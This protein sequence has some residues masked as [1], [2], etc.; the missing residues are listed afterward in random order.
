[1]DSELS[2]NMIDICPVGALTSKPF[3]YSAR[4][5]ELSRRKTVSPHDRT[6]A[7]LIVQVKNDQVMRVV[8]L[9]N[10]DVNECWLADRDRFSYEALN[11]DERLTAPMIKQ[12][13][14]WKPVDWTTALEYVAN[15]LKQ[16][17]ADHGA[18]GIG[19]L[20]RPAQHGGRAAL[21]AKLVR[22]L[23]SENIDHRLRHADFA[24]TRRRRPL[25]GHVD[26]F[27]VHAATRA[28]RRLLPAQGPS[29]VCAAHAPGGAQEAAASARDAR[30]ARRLADAG[31]RPLHCAAGQLGA[32]AG[33]RGRRHWRHKGVAAPAAGA[34]PRTSQGHRR[35]AAG[36]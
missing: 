34:M 3:R 13:G 6:G 23:G 5:W 30:R 15:G 36:G 1:M 25:A 14:E 29:A 19:A 16:I 32:G 24:D 21:L 12:G 17:K 26:R 22:G 33:R 7:N 20:A 18:D 27:A 10:E 35:V 4:T 2:G 9:E 28:G 11:S 31:C 8:P